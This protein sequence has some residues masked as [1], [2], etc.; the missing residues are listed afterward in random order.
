M[1]G[2]ERR[3]QLLKVAMHLFSENGF[4]GTTTKKIAAKA[5]VSEAMVFKHFAN[6]DELYADILDHKACDHGLVDPM[7]ELAVEIEAKN[8]FGVFYGIALRALN[9]HKEDTDFIR[10]LLH[11]ALERHE[12]TKMFFDKYV[13]VL[14]EKIGGYIAQ[15]QK[16][17]AFREIDPNIVVRAFSGMFIHHSLSNLLIDQDQTLLKISNEDAAKE[18]ATILINGIRK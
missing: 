5:G 16:D 2:D 4:S 7:D 11:S 10:L 18:F 14:Y 6:K 12:M 3:E 8:D 9:H 13:R 17:G 15:R 1:A